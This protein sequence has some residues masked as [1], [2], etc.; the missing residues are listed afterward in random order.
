MRVATL[1]VAFALVAISGSELARQAVLS[2][3]EPHP[4]LPDLYEAGV[5][6]LQDGLDAGHFTSVDLVK[7]YFARIEEVNLRGPALRAVIEVNPTALFEAQVL[8]DERV[9]LGK[10]GLLHGIPVML[11]DNM[12]TVFTEGI[13]TCLSLSQYAQ[14]DIAYATC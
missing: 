6:E 3:N 11:K 4:T 2:T 13:L 14:T 1:T 8:D 7:A 10:R 9:L 5:L 12:A